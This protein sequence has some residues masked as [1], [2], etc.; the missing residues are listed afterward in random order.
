MLPSEVFLG[1]LPPNFSKRSLSIPIGWKKLTILFIVPLVCLPASKWRW[2]CHSLSPKDVDGSFKFSWKAAPK[3]Y[4]FPLGF[5]PSLN[6]WRIPFVHFTNFLPGWFCF[7]TTQCIPVKFRSQSNRW[8]LWKT[9]MEH[10]KWTIKGGKTQWHLRGHFYWKCEGWRGFR[11]GCFA[12]GVPL[13]SARVLF[14]FPGFFPKNAETCD[15]SGLKL[16]EDSLPLWLAWNVPGH[17][18]HLALKPGQCVFSAPP[19]LMATNDAPKNAFR[20]R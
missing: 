16:P 5:A 10:L 12:F 8:N 13:S 2:R 15:A 9:P 20:T 6:P 18:R 3:K 1:N 14:H 17:V 4:F 7:L 11:G 19:L